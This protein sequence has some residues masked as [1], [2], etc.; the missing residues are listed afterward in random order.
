VVMGYSS[1]G[2]GAKLFGYEADN[3]SPYNALRLRIGGAA[4]SLP[5]RGALINSDATLVLKQ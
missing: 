3:S 2:G 4:P 5:I 1:G